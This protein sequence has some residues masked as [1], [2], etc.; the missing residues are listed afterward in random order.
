MD[1]EFAKILGI[2]ERFPASGKRLCDFW[3]RADKRELHNGFPSR[4]SMPK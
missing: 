1:D 2:D 3:L 4:R